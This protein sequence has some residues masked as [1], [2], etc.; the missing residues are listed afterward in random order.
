MQ[1]RTLQAL[2]ALVTL[3]EDVAAKVR[4]ET[5]EILLTTDP[6]EIVKHFDAV[7]DVVDRV[8]TSREALAEIADDLSTV[9]IPTLFSNR[10]LKTITIEGLGRVTVS[11]RYS[12]SML[13]KPA[14]MEWLRGN[15]HG[16]LI[17]ETVNSS[18]LGAFGREMMEA[19]TE[20]PENL[21]KTSTNPYTS[22]TKR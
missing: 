17:Q 12:V 14:G 9:Q 19:G 5:A 15:G 16:A 10:N 6:I 20:L 18:T 3:A 1:A 11:H 4:R 7:R 21:F 22:I 2:E 8:K 13:D